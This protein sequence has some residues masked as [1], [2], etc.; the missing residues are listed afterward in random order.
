MT[1]DAWRERGKALEDSFFRNVDQQL[2]DQLKQENQ[3]D[4]MR[5]ELA[6]VSGIQDEAVLDLFVELGVSPETV[7]ALA[8]APLVEV[9]W[10]DGN[11]DDKEREAL[12]EA[13]TQYGAGEGTATRRLLES[14]LQQKPDESLL[15]AWSEY[16]AAVV[17]ENSPE[18]VEAI[19]M[20]LL[21]RARSVAEATGGFL[22]LGSKISN[23]EAA[24][25]DRLAAAF[26]RDSFS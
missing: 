11:L 16:I 9:A 21:N 2:I 19:R 18:T 10:S 8:T 5:E 26:E 3:S 14:W 13:A 23:S 20:G 12:L 25:L 24:V 1:G 15:Q 22:G 17:A 4:S 7:A 6:S